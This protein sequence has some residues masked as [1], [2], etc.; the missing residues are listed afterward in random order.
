MGFLSELFKNTI[1]T[2]K[3]AQV[4]TKNTVKFYTSAKS[5]NTQKGF[6]KRRITQKV[7][8]ELTEDEL[9]FYSVLISELN[10]ENIPGK[11]TFDRMSDKTLNFAIES[12]GQIGR[13]K[14]QGRK[15]KMQFI[16]AIKGSY[17]IEVEWLENLTL[18]EMIDGIQRWIEYIPDAIEQDETFIQSI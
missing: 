3:S 13:V 16:S 14:I 17:E 10:K 9:K 12:I 7:K 2:T 18:D 6:S 8:D 1:K 5:N 11:L 4:P 15:T